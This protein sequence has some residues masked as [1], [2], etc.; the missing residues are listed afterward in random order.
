MINY[1]DP[2]IRWASKKIEVV[3]M[4]W[5]YSKTFVVEVGGNCSGFTNFDSA[6]DQ[7]YD[8]LEE[9]EYGTPFI[10]MEDSEGETCLF[11]EEGH[12]WIQKMVVSIK[13]LDI[14]EEE[15]KDW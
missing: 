9:D 6:V 14:K 1:V 15:N 8:Q 2:N 12:E 3:L 13:L 7:I 4:Q 11:E 5:A 10:V